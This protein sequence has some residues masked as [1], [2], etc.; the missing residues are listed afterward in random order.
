MASDSSLGGL[1][2]R[3]RPWRRHAWLAVLVVAVS[4]ASLVFACAVPF[5]AFGAIAALTLSRR[6]AISATLALWL[7]NQAIGYAVLGYPQTANSVGWGL[8]I[9]AA[10]V[11]ATGTAR[12][13]AARAPRAAAPA[14]AALALA[15]A[16]AVYE[17]ALLAAAV[18]LGGWGGLAAPIVGR[19][20]VI[21]A[22]ALV[23]LYGLDRAGTGIGL[24][25]VPASSTRP[26]AS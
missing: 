18:A 24:R 2:R 4:A 20:L 22:L 7:A 16:F 5:A 15:G 13:I 12:W 23:G 19:V 1:E 11:L 8:A 25:P 26:A 6:D 10:A 21:N 3:Q 9:G 14:Q 17:V